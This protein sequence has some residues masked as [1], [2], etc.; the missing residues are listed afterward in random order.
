GAVLHYLPANP[1]QALTITFTGTPHV[2]ILP[3]SVACGCG[4]YSLLGRQT[5]DIGTYQ[6]ITGFNPVPGS[7]VLTLSN[8]TSSDLVTNT[9]NGSTWSLGTPSLAVWKSAFFLVPCVPPQTYTLNLVDAGNYYLI[10]N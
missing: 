7:Q 6:N 2:P 9:F 4:V 1:N 3:A 5:N 8:S 10:A